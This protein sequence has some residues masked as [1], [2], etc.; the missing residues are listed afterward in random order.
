[1][2]TIKRMDNE[3]PLDLARRCGGYYSR[4]KGGPVV[5]YAGKYSGPNGQE[6]QWVGE[7]Y[8]NFAKVEKHASALN[9]V[10]DELACKLSAKEKYPREFGDLTRDVGFCGA[11]EGGKALAWFCNKCLQRSTFSRRRRLLR[12]KLKNLGKFPSLSL[13]VMFLKRGIGGGLLKMFAITSA[14]LQSLSR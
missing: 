11:P 3:S 2:K 7:V 6:L 8:V 9:F 5:G 12:P 13:T 4:P 1:M 14:Q 10:A